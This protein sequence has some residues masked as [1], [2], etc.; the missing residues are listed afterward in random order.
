[1]QCY[2]QYHPNKE[3]CKTCELR[4]YCKDSSESNPSMLTNR[5]KHIPTEVLPAP[6]FIRP[7]SRNEND[8]RYSRADMLEL[9]GT[10][11]ALDEKTLFILDEKIRNPLV[12]LAE[13]GRKRNLTRQAVHKFLKS[14]CEQI[15]EIAA[16]FNNHKNKK[17]PTFMEAVCQIKN[18]SSELN[19]NAPETN[20][21]SFRSLTSL[22]Q[23]LDLSRLSIGKDLNF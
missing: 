19:S 23:N 3:M 4:D 11:V 5:A 6:V 12:S 21:N 10:I 18:Q 13:I 22:S 14:R 15:P 20:S 1:M 8:K 2:S 16:V 9:I 7:S 17:N